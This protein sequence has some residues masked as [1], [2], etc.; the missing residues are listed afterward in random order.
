MRNIITLLLICVTGISVA[1][2]LTFYKDIQPLIHQKCT[3]CHRPG[4]AAP[5]NLITYDDV[6]KRSHFIK[7]VIVSR[8][9]PPWKADDHY[10]D[11]S[12]KRTLTDDQISKIVSW[13]DDDTPKGKEN[14]KAEK[15][16]LKNIQ[17]GTTYGRLPD[18]TLKMKYAYKVKNDGAERFMVFKIP[19]EMAARANVEAIEFTTNNKKIIHHA[20]FAIHPVEDPA[21][22]ITG[23]IDSIDLNTSM[24]LYEQWRPYKKEMTYYGG[25][26]P[27]TSYES[28]PKDMG[29]VMPRRG[30]VLLTIHFS[31]AAKIE[32]SISGVNFFFKQTPISRQVKVISLGSGGIGEDDITP[33][34]LLLPNEIQTH[35]LQI[36]NRREDITLLYVWPHMHYLGK[37]FTAFAM[38]E[39][40][41]LH[42]VH[43]PQ[44]DY[45][46]QEIYRYRK[47]VILKRGDIV[48]VIG[49][50]DNTTANPVNPYNPPRFIESTGD[51]RSD[52]EMLTLLLVYVVYQPNDEAL[53]FD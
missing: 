1:Q 6:S 17:A 49:T 25:W 26:I 40:D 19:F 31:P 21:I 23:T 22:D 3:S 41:T 12:N 38:H 11:F 42:L 36:T 28:Y 24:H 15:E 18:L 39:D 50:Y 48:K 53:S 45:R 44:W 47:P 30:V 27:G 9:M 4:G 29:W 32:E 51:M 7:K 34:L 35:R 37:E 52:Q 33:P 43:I 2:K 13:I 14:T 16:L 10:N 8:Y 20:N 5:F 46:W